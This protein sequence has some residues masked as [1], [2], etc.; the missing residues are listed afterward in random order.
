MNPNLQSALFYTMSTIAQT[1]SGAMGLLGAI[2]LFALQET[3]RSIER[4]A[5]K[6][7]E[8]PHQSMSQLYLRHL[9][10]RRS[11]HEL[12]RH[13][14]DE[15]QPGGSTQTSAEALV[16]FSTL[17]WELDH[18][19]ALRR[20]FW[21]ALLASGIVIAASLI[22]C[23]LAPQLATSTLVGQVVLAGAIVGAVAC[24]ILYGFLLR[25][26]LRSTPQEPIPP[27]GG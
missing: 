25:V 19:H 22:G 12:A 18:D 2:V 4:A 1:L 5:R 7:T 9:L 3:S 23:G 14:G 13:Y 21:R 8:I 27:A 10:T 20:S 6:L 26:M 24:L 17:T 15:L 11:F 16:H